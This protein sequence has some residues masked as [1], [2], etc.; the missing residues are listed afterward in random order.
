MNEQ[1]LC[2]CCKINLG[3]GIAINPE[4]SGHERV[5]VPPVAIIYETLELI[6]VYKCHRC[7]YSTY[8]GAQKRALATIKNSR[9]YNPWT[10][11]PLA[12][13]R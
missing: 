1:L 4:R 8:D 12:S 13:S 9:F 5:R 10:I 6:E 11:T 7:G 3:R 2:P